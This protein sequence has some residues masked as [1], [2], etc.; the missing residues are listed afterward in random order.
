MLNLLITGALKYDKLFFGKLEKLGVNL[1][2]EQNELERVKRDVSGFDMLICN[3]LFLYNDIDKFKSLKYIQITSVGWDRLPVDKIK[4]KNI[5]LRN[6]GDIYAIPMAEWVVSKIMEI[7]K[8]SRFFYSN[9]QICTW[10]KNR[11]I[12]ELSGKNVLIAGAGNVGLQVAKRLA[13]FEMNIDAVDSRAVNSPYINKCYAINALIDILPSYDV[14][15][16]ALPLTGDTKYLFDKNLFGRIK[17]ACVLINV[18][19]GDIIKE[20]D[21]INAIDDNV[22]LGVALDVFHKEPLPKSSP[23]WGFNNVLITP[24][25]SFISDNVQNRLMDLIYKNLC[26]YV[27]EYNE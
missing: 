22:F 18:S 10:T 17:K 5:I 7:Y 2:F 8:Q 11:D 13:A 21:L 19:R 3:A 23:L 15:V 6:A 12:L 24:H 25:N 14:I 1:C 26:V 4:E 20:D 16:L 27:A 9:K